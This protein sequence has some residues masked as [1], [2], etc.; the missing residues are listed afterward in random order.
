MEI[1]GIFVQYVAFKCIANLLQNMVA[2]ESEELSILITHESLFNIEKC[3]I[4]IYL[5][6]LKF[7]FWHSVSKEKQQV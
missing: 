7:Y 3:C 4:E 5:A 6:R 1:V 2:R